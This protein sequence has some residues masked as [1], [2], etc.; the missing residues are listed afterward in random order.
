MHLDGQP[1]SL[2]TAWTVGA[3]RG[4]GHK[5]IPR[6]WAGATRGMELLHTFM[7]KEG[8]FPEMKMKGSG[9]GHRHE[10]SQSEMTVLAPAWSP[11][12]RIPGAQGGGKVE[13]CGDGQSGEGRWA[14]G[15]GRQG[16]QGWGRR[17]GVSG[18]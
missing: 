12:V 8:E 5:S 7:R 17:A 13:K 2:L 14:G 11:T 10:G 1:T 9:S 4:R 18:T 16:G 3:V 6:L 15:R